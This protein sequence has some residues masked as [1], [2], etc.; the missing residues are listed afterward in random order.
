MTSTA[1]RHPGLLVPQ[2]AQVDE[3]SGGRVALR[4]GAG[5]SEREHAAYSIPFPAS[6]GEWFDHLEL[7]AS[8]MNQ[9]V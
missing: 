1:F 9:V 5:W 4:L 7:M 3:M 6:A 2:V 8:V